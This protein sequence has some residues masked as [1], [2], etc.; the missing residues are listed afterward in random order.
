MENTMFRLGLDRQE[1]APEPAPATEHQRYGGHSMVAPLRRVIVQQPAPPANPGD[2]RAYGYSGPVD[3]AATMAEFEAFCGVL[4]D[5]G[6]D[7][8]VQEPDAPGRLDSIFVYDSAIVTDEGAILTHPGKEI[9][10]AEVEYARSLYE[11]LS[12]PII[13]EIVGDGILEGGD[14]F[15]LSETLLAAGIGYRT[16]ATGVDQLTIFVRH[17]GVDVIRVDLPHWHGP[18]ECLHLLSL[19]SPV[20][21]RK[22]VIFSPLVST[23]FMQLLHA[24]DWE[25]I[26]I[27][28]A[29][30]VTQATNVLALAPNK[31]LMLEDNTGTRQRL[32]T[33]GVEVLT[34]QGNQLSHNRQGGPTCLTRALW[35]DAVPTP[36]DIVSGE[37]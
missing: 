5:A 27:P 29:E 7:L 18:D 10:R 19:I 8:I 12:V 17:L 3:H 21:E 9:R 6:V 14:V 37:A 26:E 20:A 11:H 16:N 13:G 23:P 15:W 36:G 28:E 25:L 34:Y 31:V 22:A 33:A 1:T 4:A 24:L 35:R 32:E 2:W 30:F